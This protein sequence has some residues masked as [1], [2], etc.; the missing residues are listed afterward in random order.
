MNPTHSRG[1]RAWARSLTATVAVVATTAF[2]A[3]CSSTAPA[4]ATTETSSGPLIDAARCAEN[5]AAGKLTYVN[6]FGNPRPEILYAITQGW[7]KDNFCLDVDMVTDTKTSTQIVSAGTAQITST[8]SISNAIQ[9]ADAGLNLTAIATLSYKSQYTLLTQ[10]QYTDLKQLEG[11]TIGYHTIVPIPL[12]QMLT[13]AGV[14][15]STINWVND[16]TY[17]PTLLTSGAYDAIQAYTNNEPLT[18]KSKGL[19]FNEYDPGDYGIT[20]SSN[21]Y[22]ANTTYLNEHRS[23]VQDWLLQTLE[24]YQY[25]E[26]N[27]DDCISVVQKAVEDSG[28]SYD[29]QHETDS[30]MLTRQAMDENT[31]PGKGVG[32][33][34]PEAWQGEF[35]SLV[36]YDQIK[37]AR[38]IDLTKLVDSTIADELYEDGQLLWPGKD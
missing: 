7:Y 37:N 10:K 30:W 22:L 18:L 25:C 1:V 4:P 9:Y 27:I 5:E 14:D 2:L 20:G 16:T 19:E 26:A 29:K 21:V 8:G 24:A 28:Q 6:T 36:Q 13:K 11:K 3:A 12:S 33:Q 31:L 15:V 17:N 35:I 38:S 34:T 23:A 32:Q